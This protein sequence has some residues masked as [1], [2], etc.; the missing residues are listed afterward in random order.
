MSRHNI[1][2]ANHH[3]TINM[4]QHIAICNHQS[5]QLQYMLQQ[6]KKPQIINKQ[7]APHFA[8]RSSTRAKHTDRSPVFLSHGMANFNEHM[9]WPGGQNFQWGGRC[10]DDK[11][12]MCDMYL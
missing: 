2:L 4:Q 5:S 12:D 10:C 1:Q 7:A 8:S 6:Q 11:Y 9:L 3:S